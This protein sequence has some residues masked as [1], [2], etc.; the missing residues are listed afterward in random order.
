MSRF[1]SIGR[2]RVGHWR[3]EKDIIAL[4]SS[5]ALIYELFIISMVKMSH[6][7]YRH[8]GLKVRCILTTQEV[9]QFP[10]FFYGYIIVALGFIIAAAVEGLMFSFGI[11]FKPLLTEFGWTRAMTSGAISLSAIINIPIVIV[12]GRLTDRFGSRPVLIACGFFFGLGHLLMSQTNAMWQLYLFYGVIVAMGIG[13]YWVPVISLVPRWFVQRRALMM[14]I[15]ASGIGIGQIIYPPVVNWLISTYGWR[16]SFLLAG[17]VTMGIIMIVAQFLKRDPR[18][19]GLLPYGQS[20]AEK[21][22]LVAEARRFSLSEALHSKQLWM[23]GVMFL[24]WC[25]CLSTVMVHSVVH[26]IGIGMSSASAA[27]ILAIIGITGIVGRIAFG[28]LADTVGMKPILILSF[29]LMSAAFLWLIIASE[30][31]MLYLFAAVFGVSYGV[32]E[33]LHSPIIANLF[34]LSSFGTISGVIMIFGSIGFTIGPVLAGHIFDVT[35]SYEMAFL[36]C[37]AMAIICLICTIFLPL[38]R[39]RDGPVAYQAESS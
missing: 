20:E 14:G 27:N 8:T 25:I 22:S 38:M 16:M 29:A 12:S 4:S 28:R 32:F 39:D 1:I 13:L 35:S 10:T 37:A 15:I 7:C 2:L 30:T 36:I 6:F 19:M 33:I 18:Q 24:T 11:F 23:L 17:G 3:R 26:A 21:E 31:W 9:R 5:R 34:G